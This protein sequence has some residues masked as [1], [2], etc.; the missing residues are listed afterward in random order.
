MD[1]SDLKIAVF[2]GLTIELGTRDDTAV[3]ARDVF[4]FSGRCE[5]AIC[6]GFLAVL[7]L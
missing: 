2:V 7:D 3:G 4:F 6:I 5:N 1:S